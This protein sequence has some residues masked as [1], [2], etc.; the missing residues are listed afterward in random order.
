[1]RDRAIGYH[2]ITS[3]ASWRKTHSSISLTPQVRADLASG[4]ISHR[5][6]LG[7]RTSLM[8]RGMGSVI[9]S[10]QICTAKHWYKHAKKAVTEISKPS[11][12]SVKD[13]DS[14]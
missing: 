2:K 13:V 4:L 9:G 7:G 3:N 10:G 11:E 5:F 12:P 6:S 14:S 8:F 1:M